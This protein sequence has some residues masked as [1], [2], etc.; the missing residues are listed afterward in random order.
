MELITTLKPF[1][2]GMFVAWL[3]MKRL[4]RKAKG[5]EIKEI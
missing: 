5:F 4:S 3:I 2:M 1:V